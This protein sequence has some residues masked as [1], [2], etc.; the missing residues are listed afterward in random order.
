MAL[1]M[2]ELENSIKD[3]PEPETQENETELEASE[4]EPGHEGEPEAE[5][6]LES[7]PELE[8][9]AKFK[10]GDETVTG[11]D[12]KAE[13]LRQADYTRKTQLLAEDRKAFE[14]DRGA[15]S[16]ENEELK[17]WVSSLKDPEEMLFELDRYFPDT[18]QAMRDLI[19]Q[20]AI[21]E[22]DM[23]PTELDATRRARKA[24]HAEKARQKDQ[25]LADKKQA[26]RDMEMKTAELRHTFNDW[27]QETMTEAG[28]DPKNP[29]HQKFVRKEVQTEHKGK[30]WTKDTFQE[31]C[32]EVAGAMGLEPKSQ[33]K[34]PA[35]PPTQTSGHKRPA[36][37]ADKAARDK[38]SSED[39]FKNLRSGN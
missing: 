38:A 37:R 35:L 19:I 34:K 10:I 3:E 5:P 36:A 18:F 2:A 22:Q 29:K 32:K 12:L 1:N 20:Q 16:E 24:E 4:N 27:L 6:E 33:A 7:D 28:L 13:R 11:K 17:T 26:R 39:F 30:T 23:T 21:Q 9:E 15:L 25:D 31:A 8:D 14:A